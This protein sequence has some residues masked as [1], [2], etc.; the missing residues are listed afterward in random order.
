MPTVTI[1]RAV[2][3]M[4]KKQFDD[5]IDLIEKRSHQLLEI[6]NHDTT[7]TTKINSIYGSGDKVVSLSSLLVPKI[8]NDPCTEF[9]S[10]PNMDHSNIFK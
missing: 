9:Y 4:N 10:M 7:R 1:P 5:F 8:W 2:E 6:K 3:K